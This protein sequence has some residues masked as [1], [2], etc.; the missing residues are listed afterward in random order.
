MKETVIDQSVYKMWLG[1]PNACN[2][3]AVLKTLIDQ[4]D[5]ILT[6]LGAKRTPHFPGAL[7]ALRN[8]LLEYGTTTEVEYKYVPEGS[9]IEEQELWHNDGVEAMDHVRYTAG[10]VN[11]M[12]APATG[13]GQAPARQ[14]EFSHP[15][16]VI[17]V[18]MVN[19][20]LNNR[21]GAYLLKDDYSMWSDA[22]SIIKLHAYATSITPTQDGV[23][24]G[25]DAD[26]YMESK[27]FGSLDWFGK[28]MLKAWNGGWMRLLDV[29][30]YDDSKSV[31]IMGLYS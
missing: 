18:Q 3:A 27:K 20:V 2:P 5:N 16:V 13:A 28:T 19:N 6:D 30:R 26:G 8:D 25:L 22:Y 11:R 31:T 1:V 24:I 17:A 21:R 29:D 12:T 9:P 7:I 23:T 4:A 10:E 14:Y 15:L